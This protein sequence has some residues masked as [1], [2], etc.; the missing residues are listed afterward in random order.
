MRVPS[1]NE[2]GAW[3][4]FWEPGGFTSGGIPEAVVNTI[5]SDEYIVKNIFKC[6]GD[7][8]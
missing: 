8:L 1:C 4:G 6:L 3:Q 7:K 5:K 2:S